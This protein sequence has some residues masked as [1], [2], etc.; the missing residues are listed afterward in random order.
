LFFLSTVKIGIDAQ[1]D[2]SYAAR[3][4]KKTKLTKDDPEFYSKIAAI[5][6]KK[7]VR[8]RGTEYFSKLAAKSHPRAEYHGGRP[9][10][11]A[12]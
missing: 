2:L 5:A 6:G 11:K 1:P 3:M 4:V 7:L 10:K 9:K 12:A 8:L